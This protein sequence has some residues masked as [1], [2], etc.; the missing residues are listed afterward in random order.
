MDA[1]VGGCMYVW[2]DGWMSVCMN[3]IVTMINISETTDNNLN[4]IVTCS[5]L[6]FLCKS[7]FSRGEFRGFV[8]RAYDTLSLLYSLIPT[9]FETYPLSDLQHF[10]VVKPFCKKCKYDIF[11]LQSHAQGYMMHTKLHKPILSDL[12]WRLISSKALCVND[13]SLNI[14]WIVYYMSLAYAWQHISVL[15]VI[16]MDQSKV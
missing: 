11:V 10:V 12:P 5:T 7:Q 14:E 15:Y 9:L 4:F 1:Q 3:G 2:M 6:I 13:A 16:L 8:F